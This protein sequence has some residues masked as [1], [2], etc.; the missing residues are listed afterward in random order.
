[1]SFKTGKET[2]AIIEDYIKKGFEAIQL[3]PCI[4][5]KDKDGNVWKR[6]QGIGDWILFNNAEKKCVVITEKLTSLSSDD[7]QILRYKR[8]PAA[9]QTRIDDY[10]RKN[11]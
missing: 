7:H 5:I 1:M 2:K 10:Y 3:T 9:I 4:I 11:K 6:S 8:I